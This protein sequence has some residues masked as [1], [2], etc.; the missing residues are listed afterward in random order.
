M[1]EHDA[2]RT[3]D[4]PAD[5]MGEYLR[6]YL[7]ETGEQL[8]ALVNTL[9]ALEADPADGSGLN[10]A[11][12][13]I[14]SIKGSSALLGL[15]RIT[16]L[17]HHLE[18]HFERLRSGR[19]VLDGEVMNVVLRC[20]DFLRTCNEHLRMGEPLESAGD[21]L[22]QVKAL[23][24]A[25]S[26]SPADDGPAGQGSSR[27]NAD[28]AGADDAASVPKGEGSFWRIRVRFAAALPMAEMKAELILT[29]LE[30]LGTVA[31]L[32][33]PRSTLPGSVGLPG[34]E[35]VLL[36]NASFDDME[37]A[38][39]ADGV[40]HTLIESVPP[41]TQAASQPLADDDQGA[42]EDSAPRAG[43]A[44]VVEDSGEPGAD[45]LVAQS[46]S[47]DRGR[48]STGL[49]ETVRVDVDRLDVLL[50]LTGE[51]VVNRA[52][53]AQ[54]A[55]DMAP[56][57]GKT[58][59]AGR[60]QTVID[61]L[62]HLRGNIDTAAAGTVADVLEQIESLHQQARLWDDSR[63]RF[64]E[65]TAAIDQLTRVSNSLQRGVLNTR[66]VPVGPLFNRFRRTVRDIARELGKRVHLELVGEKT[67]LDKRMIDE[68][69]DPLNHL[70]RNCIDHG[71]EPVDVRL[72]HGKP[73]VATVR[74]SAAHRGNSVFITV[75][76]DGG[77]IDTTRVGEIAVDRGLLAADTVET[78]A[79]RDLIELIWQ[80]GFSTARAVSD[81][82]GRGVGMD[83]VRTKI[84]ALNGSIDVESAGGVGTRFTIRL[85]LT[86]T[87][88]RCMLFRLPHGVVAV[89]IENVREIV[90][91][92]SH[93]KVRV[94]GRHICDIRGEMLP[95]VTADDL[96][97]WSGEPAV[98]SS[99]AETVVIL[100]ANQRLLG[101]RVDA[102]LGGQDIVVK[103]LDE[104]FA[105]VRGLGGASTLG[106]GSVCLLLDVANCLD[107]IQRAV[108]GDPIAASQPQ[109]SQP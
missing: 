26:P 57:F 31:D 103:P 104:Q 56:A 78:L 15:D 92:A 20:I 41:G 1:S 83:I 67:E 12:R 49:V 59:L 39:R 63:Q 100:T 6:L 101:L 29:R 93:A 66:M 27:D 5:E 77:G 82:S 10:E 14:H 55:G 30:Q 80:P 18:S 72:R 2:P 71:I 53:L 88:T 44:V 64:A 107:T 51:L 45:L 17:T 7:D 4:F 97:S 38:C 90:S 48:G 25:P 84:A 24:R 91:V 95:V 50:N 70:V 60:T 87:I 52:R 76:D 47:N 28:D 11:F 19:R 75:E 85:P 109:R 62:E 96:F 34:F 74:L 42:R 81:I 105:H 58:T 79:E 43:E 69:G 108:G 86:L 36:S 21:L 61:S 37:L 54:L 13:L 40:E 102:L 8:D 94:N 33:P 16:T 89:P 65:L 68:I 3:S 99:G 23:E 98:P 9:L 46:A 73:E 35:A 32:E 22:D 106:D